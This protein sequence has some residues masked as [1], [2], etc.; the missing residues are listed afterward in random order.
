MEEYQYDAFV[1]YSNLDKVFVRKLIGRLVSDGI[2]VFYDESDLFV[3]NSI[4]QTLN[5]AVA[6]SKYV[7]IVMSPSYF[8]SKWASTELELAMQREFET[9]TTTVLPILAEKCDVPPLLR[10]KLYLDFTARSDFESSYRK[11]LSALVSKPQ[12][13][14]IVGSTNVVANKNEVGTIK[15]SRSESAILLKEIQELNTRVSKFMSKDTSISSHSNA[16]EI[17]PRLCFVIMPFSQEELTDIYEYF[18]KPS[19]EENCDLVCERGDDVFGSNIIME[20]IRGSIGKARIIVADLTGRNPNVFYEVG[21]AHAL[22]KQVLLLSQSMSDVPFDL[23]HR[24]VLVYDNTPKG[25]KKLEKS[26]V[27]NVRAMLR[28][29]E[30]QLTS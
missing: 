7:L 23:R 13:F 12:P 21:I 16:V 18:I 26:L 2:L 19:I 28:D 29:A 10:N 8:S 17:S 4:T 24:R 11:L 6:R 25:C 9:D 30:S 1:S 15:V 22:D 20:D 27:E 14:S 3:G 5:S